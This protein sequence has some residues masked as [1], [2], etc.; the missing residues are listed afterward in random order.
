MPSEKP[1]LYKNKAPYKSEIPTALKDY[2]LS[3]LFEPLIEPLD[4]ALDERFELDKPESEETCQKSVFSGKEVETQ[5]L[6]GHI[7]AE[8]GFARTA[9]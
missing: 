2:A 9:F 6:P 4:G 3:D 7:P 8:S 1:E 5:A